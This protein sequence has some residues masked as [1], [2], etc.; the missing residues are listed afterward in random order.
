MTFRFLVV[1]H[2]TTLSPI[3][4]DRLVEMEHIT[5]DGKELFQR[6]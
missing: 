2:C 6:H 4:E 3:Q 1:F 5:L